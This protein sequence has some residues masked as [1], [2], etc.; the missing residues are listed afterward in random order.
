MLVVYFILAG[1]LLVIGEATAAMYCPSDALLPDCHY[2]LIAW[3]A[4]RLDLLRSLVI[5]IPL[6][7]A[8]D[9]VS[10]TSFFGMYALFCYG[11][12]ALLRLT[13]QKLPIPETI[14]RLP[15]TSISYL[16]FSWILYALLVLLPAEIEV[17]PWSWSVM[18]SRTAWVLALTWPFFFLFDLLRKFAGRN[19][20]P[21]HKLH[22]RSDNR[23]RPRPEA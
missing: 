1:L 10:G 13:S 8:M 16:L 21:F 2:I 15:L 23:R 11:S 5:L 17:A 7:C 9:A 18:L 12:Y 3:L 22:L 19:I 14:Y 6:S 4:Y 20:L